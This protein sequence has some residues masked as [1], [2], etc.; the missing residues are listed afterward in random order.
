MGPCRQPWDPV[1][2]SELRQA[3]VAPWGWVWDPADCGETQWWCWTL[4]NSCRSGWCPWDPSDD[5]GNNQR[6]WDPAV[7][8]GLFWLTMLWSSSPHCCFPVLPVIPLVLAETL[9][10][11]WQYNGE[12]W[13]P[14]HAVSNGTGWPFPCVSIPTIRCIHLSIKV[15][16][17]STIWVSWFSELMLLYDY[18]KYL[19]SEVYEMRLTRSPMFSHSAL[20]RNKLN[21]VGRNTAIR[22][23]SGIVLLETGLCWQNVPRVLPLQTP[24]YVEQK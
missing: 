4:T 1:Y 3:A 9:G 18:F 21:L 24:R 6:R 12:Y 10:N 14:C 22:Q 19:F 8:G 16:L 7:H 13:N 11:V 5:S 20:L 2:G 23:T 15:R 17:F